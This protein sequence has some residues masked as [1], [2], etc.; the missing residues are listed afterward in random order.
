MPHNIAEQERLYRSAI[1]HFQKALK[2]NT[3]EG[4]SDA[5]L[6]DEARDCE[7]MLDE[8]VES[9]AA[10]LDDGAIT[11]EEHALISALLGTG[12]SVFKDAAMYIRDWANTV[13]D[14]IA[15]RNLAAASDAMRLR[16]GSE[17]IDVH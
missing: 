3:P 2:N 17:R 11:A 6:S 14:P 10:M 16:W 5:F 8:A 15:C 12:I 9:Y 1:Q 4:I 7:A 13:A